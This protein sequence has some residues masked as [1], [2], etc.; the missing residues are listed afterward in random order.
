MYRLDSGKVIVHYP[1]Y[2][3]V[4][5]LNEKWEIRPTSVKGSTLT[6]HRYFCSYIGGFEDTV[7]EDE[8]GTKLYLNL[9]DVQEAQKNFRQEQYERAQR[10][11]TA[12]AQRVSETFL[13]TQ[14]PLFEEEE[15]C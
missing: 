3:K 1:G 4:G 11:L 13:K 9:E 14:E 7:L 2:I 15:M 5:D 8:F 12:A 10:E 6:T